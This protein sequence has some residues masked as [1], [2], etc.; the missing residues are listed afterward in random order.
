MESEIKSIDSAIIEVRTFTVASKSSSS[1][2]QKK[3]KSP[4]QKP[5]PSKTKPLVNNQPQL[6]TT[7]SPSNNNKQSP[8]KNISFEVIPRSKFGMVT[9]PPP[10]LV[11]LSQAPFL[12]ASSDATQS[13][14]GKAKPKL[15]LSESPRNKQPNRPNL[16]RNNDFKAPNP[17]Q[18]QMRHSN[19]EL[20]FKDTNLKPT[21]PNQQ[22]PNQNRSQIKV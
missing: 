16:Q 15:S 6:K 12:K 21:K 3:I 22:Y 7:K 2:S 14:L 13:P 5:S 20:I 9:L 19:S 1:L 17:T 8:Q 10:N 11:S 4:K 18:N